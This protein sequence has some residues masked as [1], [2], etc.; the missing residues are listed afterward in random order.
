MSDLVL[1]TGA[2]GKTGRSLAA[3]LAEKGVACRAASRGGDTPFDWAQPETWDVALEGA[4]SIYLVAPVAVA[5]AYSRMTAFLQSAMRQGARRFVLLS[6]AS[7]PAGGF[8]PG[9][10]HQ[11]LKDNSGDWAVLAPSAFMQNF[12]EGPFLASIRGED[13]PGGIGVI[14]RSKI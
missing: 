8:G 5:D 10:V 13:R 2:T 1:I 7:I 6:M 3:L 14:R 9:Q 12:S 4:S 11:W